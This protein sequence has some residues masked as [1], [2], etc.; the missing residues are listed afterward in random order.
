MDY[1]L[2]SSRL[3]VHGGHE[4]GDSVLRDGRAGAVSLV[5]SASPA[6]CFAGALKMV[7]SA[8]GP[9]PGVTLDRGAAA[10]TECF[11]RS[12]RQWRARWSAGPR[13]MEERRGH[14]P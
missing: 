2:L 1:I 5:L 7:L 8:V 12:I 13:G 4:C 10:A 9:G 6:W 11:G 3:D 14:D